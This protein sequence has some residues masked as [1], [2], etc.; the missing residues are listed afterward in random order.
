MKAKPE[1]L[2]VANRKLNELKETFFVRVGLNPSRVQHFAELLISGVELPPLLVAKDT[3]DVVDGRHRKTAH[4]EVG[5]TIVSC[6]IQKFESRAEMILEA[7][8]RNVGGSLPPERADIN[9]TMEILLA[10]G[11]SRKEIIARM[12]DLVGFPPK[13]IRLHLDEVQSSI[14]AARLSRAVK[15]VMN[16]GKTVPEAAAEFGVKL[17]T[18]QKQIE[19]KA[20]KRA[21]NISHLKSW[22]GGRFGSL[23]MSNAQNLSNLLKDLKDGVVSEVDAK[24]VLEHVGKL[25]ARQ[26]KTYDDWN[27]RFNAQFGVT[28]AIGQLPT[29]RKKKDKVAGKTALARMELT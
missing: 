2:E 18:L 3:N 19:P 10:D 29:P 16:E 5:D 20:D 22:F 11:V 25:I 28:T 12:S 21:T 1:R 4:E 6:E 17:E 27:K 23:N 8:R 9:H 14:G 15:A 7:L 24:G 26:A 13:L